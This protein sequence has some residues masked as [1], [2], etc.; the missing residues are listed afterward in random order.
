MFAP[1]VIPVAAG[2]KIANA[3]QN[4]ILPS[5]AA[6]RFSVSR[7]LS[8]STMP[9][10]R[11]AS[12]DSSKIARTK[13]WAFSATSAPLKVRKNRPAT[14]IVDPICATLSASR[15][16]TASAPATFPITPNVASVKPIV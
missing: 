2:K 10:M 16:A 4:V 7:A 11:N 5:H 14:T 12:T 9:P 8:N 1:A 3:A 13:Y 6:A 15:V